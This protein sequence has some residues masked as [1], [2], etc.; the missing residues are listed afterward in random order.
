MTAQDCVEHTCSTHKT[1][2]SGTAIQISLFFR[3]FAPVTLTKTAEICI[4]ISVSVAKICVVKELTLRRHLR[5]KY[6][7]VVRSAKWDIILPVVHIGVAIMP[8]LL[9]GRCLQ[10]SSGL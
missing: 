7:A 6:I 8:A 5:R 2:L 10:E 9:A 4:I 1:G 3:L